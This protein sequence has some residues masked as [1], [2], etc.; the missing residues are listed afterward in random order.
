MGVIRTTRHRNVRA[1]VQSTCLC[2]FD[3]RCGYELQGN[4]PRVRHL[5]KEMWGRGKDQHLE[6]RVLLHDMY[7]DY[8]LAMN[9]C[10]RL[11][12]IYY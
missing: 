1:L 7:D 8:C 3:D 10:D 12:Y 11:E 5:V 4:T 9:S 2:S 6:G